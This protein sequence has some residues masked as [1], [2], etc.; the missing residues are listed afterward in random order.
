MLEKLF[1]METTNT[2]MQSRISIALEDARESWTTMEGM[3]KTKLYVNREGRYHTSVSITG[4][5]LSYGDF[6]WETFYPDAALQLF[7]TISGVLDARS[8]VSKTLYR[9]FCANWD[10]Q[11]LDFLSEHTADYCGYLAYCASLRG[12]IARL[13]AYF[14][15][16]E[17]HGVLTDSAYP[18]HNSDTAWLALACNQH[19][20][21]MNNEIIRWDPLS[22]FSEWAFGGEDMD[23]SANSELPEWVDTIFGPEGTGWFNLGS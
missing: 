20:A 21:W 2:V 14:D 7:P 19:I 13:D 4:K 15:Q 3:L 1:V 6:S 16:L 22:T 5:R 17:Q 12:D 10:W 11:E 9:K 18:G 8:R 23:E